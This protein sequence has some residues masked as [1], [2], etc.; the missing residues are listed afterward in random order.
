MTYN[1][2]QHSNVTSATSLANPLVTAIHLNNY[3]R[4]ASK[5]IANYFSQIQ[6]LAGK[7]VFTVLDNVV[8]V[9]VFYYIPY[10]HQA[11]DNS[12]INS[13]GK[14]LSK[15]YK[16]PVQLRLVRL[17]YPYLNSSILAQLIAMNT[18]KYNFK[19]I[20]TR[21]FRRVK[22]SN[23]K[24]PALLPSQI[25]GIKVKISGRLLKQRSIPRKTVQTTQIGSFS[26]SLIASANKPHLP[27]AD[28]AVEYATFTG[29]NKKGA[30]TVK[31]WISQKVRPS[32]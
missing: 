8:L 10:A 22:V 1:T 14:I 23:S 2:L 15:V 20:M 18:Q 26:S 3:N 17:H 12:T 21:L 7:P 6:A 16:R 27:K 24:S 9:N 4:I 25:V 28:G 32:I 29:K 30:F 11:L 19:A 5:L 31:V 13:L